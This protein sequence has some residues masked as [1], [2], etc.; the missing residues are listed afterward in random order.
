MTRLLHHWLR[1]QADLCPRA[2]AVVLGNERVSYGHLEETSNRLANALI[3]TGCRPGDRVA[4]LLGKSPLAL[5]VIHAILKAGGVYVPV[6]PAGPAARVSRIL[7]AAEPRVLLATTDNRKLVRSMMA[8][9]EDGPNVGTVWLDGDSEDDPAPTAFTPGELNSMPAEPPGV[10]R[11]ADDPAHILFT[12]GSTGA[13]KG[14]TITHTNVIA[15]IEW[16]RTYFGIS[17]DDRLSGHAPLHFDL[18]TFDLFG[19]MSAGAELHLVPPR[20]NVLPNKLA[21]FIRQS[22]LT[23]WF[24]VPSVLS[25]MAKFDVVKQDDF[26]DL[27]R[28]M[29]CGEVFPTA[30]LIH[31]M[32][33]LPHVRF[34]N[35]YGPTEATIASSY[36]TLEAPPSS[37]TEPVPIG[38]PCAGEDLLVLDGER[39]AV[40]PRTV[41]DLYIAGS[42]LSPGYWRDREKTDA[43]FIRWAGDDGAERRLYKTGDLAWGDE[44]GLVY[45][46][47]RADSQV[48]SRGYRIELGE[49]EA[50]LNSLKI[51]RECAVV[52]LDSEGFEGSLICCA[53]A[54]AD[55][56]ATPSVVAGL[57]RDLL[58][59]YMI[60]AHWL[61]L[62][63][64][65][66]NV[67]GKIDRPRLREAARRH[68][69]QP[70]DNPET[71]DACRSPCTTRAS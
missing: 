23:Q 57:L 49:I 58:P 37:P 13:P 65:P 34:T 22:R 11:R 70:G 64:L 48:K 35:L 10:P 44:A 69:A 40:P 2:A 9:T 54:P 6:D 62:D 28:L 45:F 12:S 71:D 32:E 31:W 42:G 68:V 56:G 36:H 26:P 66:K 7:R 8:A 63:G 30:S 67:N 17:S 21:D 27:R 24:S 50:A 5:V 59:A 16:A 29:W 51:L 14:V 46:V 43:A 33:R 1:E 20:L 61:E 53:Y 25:Y 60:P 38:R 55:E 39:R 47:G 52:A 3:E 4:F 15:F 41:G 18:S 19:A